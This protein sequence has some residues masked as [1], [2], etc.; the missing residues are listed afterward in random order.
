MGQKECSK[1]RKRESFWVVFLLSLFPTAPSPSADT[2]L[3]TE[4]PEA[5]LLQ[6]QTQLSTYGFYL[7][8]V[9]RSPFRECINGSYTHT[10]FGSVV[11]SYVGTAFLGC[12]SLG[13][14]CMIAIWRSESE[15]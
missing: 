13:S 12:F 5:W 4:S 6:Q 15:V 9:V 11:F 1:E 7:N 3:L 10:L 8:I 14:P 2:T